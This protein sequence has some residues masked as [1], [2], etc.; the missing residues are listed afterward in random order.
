MLNSI[1]KALCAFCLVAFATFANAADWYRFRGP[2]LNGISTESGWQT[3]WPADGPKR[4]WKA[5]VGTGFSSVSVSHARLY[6]MGNDGVRT[7]TV[8]CFDAATGAEIWKHAYPCV[9]DPHFYEGGPSA[10]P[11]VDDDR[12]YSLSRKGD[13]F[14]FDAAKG[15]VLW[16]INVNKDLGDEIPTWGFAGSPLVE[17]DLLILNVGSMGTALDK[18]TGKVVWSS[19]KGPSGYASPVPF[20][21][22]GQHGVAIM[23]KHT[24][25]AVKPAT[26][27]SLWRFPWKTQYDV[28]AADPIIFDDKVFISSGYGH[29]AAL[30]DI[31]HG[32]PSLVW[33]NKEFRNHIATSVLWKGFLYGVDDV[34][35]TKY[36]L[37]CLDWKT[38]AMKWGEGSFGKGS[39]MM[40][41]G[42]IIGLSDKGVLIIIEPSPE[43]FRPIAT[44]QVL[45]GKCW[46]APVLSNGRIYCRN[47]RGDLV[48]V[49]V[50]G[51]P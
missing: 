39:L 38:G 23:A 7:D 44:A 8:F 45:G 17:G 41:D 5:S 48:C 18:K 32:K 11:T 42:K 37:K 50:A 49:D 21:S 4:L 9:L 14:C 30:L 10:T 47:S 35:N 15:S 51:K 43:G 33:E 12:V 27:K 20:D 19:P 26:G 31:S 13:L 22:G 34:S 25:E 29:G 40:A 28:N 1:S 6:T 36:Q 3:Q 2:D 46:T 24:L 16:S